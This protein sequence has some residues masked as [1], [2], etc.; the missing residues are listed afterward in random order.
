MGRVENEF[1]YN[2]FS[3]QTCAVPNMKLKGAPLLLSLVVLSGCGTGEPRQVPSLYS[4]EL[5]SPGPV[6]PLAWA[7]STQSRLRESLTPEAL[8][9]QI[10]HAIA[11]REFTAEKP[12][13]NLS[14]F[15]IN[16]LSS[17]P[18]TVR[19]PNQSAPQ[20][21]H[22]MKYLERW[23]VSACGHF[24]NWLLFDNAEDIGSALTLLPSDE[25]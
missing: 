20:T 19:M 13:S 17:E 9:R 2:L 15:S 18:F 21:F 22:P 10:L 1:F 23:R 3:P 7:L 8:H 25:G 12:C 5:V 16:E 6:S 4:I 11:R 14:I 24:T